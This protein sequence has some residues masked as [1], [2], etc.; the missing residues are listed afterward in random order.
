MRSIQSFPTNITV[1]NY[2]GLPHPSISSDPLSILILKQT[3]HNT[4]QTNKSSTYP[5]PLIKIIFSFTI[6][7]TI[8]L[9]ISHSLHLSFCFLTSTYNL[10]VTLSHTTQQKPQILSTYIRGHIPLPRLPP[11]HTCHASSSLSH[12]CLTR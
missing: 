2:D 1:P 7:I 12:N 6:I 8:L 11:F 10:H 4:T 9:S 3:Q 5:Y